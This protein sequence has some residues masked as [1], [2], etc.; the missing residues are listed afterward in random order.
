MN[1]HTKENVRSSVYSF[2]TS[3]SA[4]IETSQRDIAEQCSHRA[5][6]DS[7]PATS[8]EVAGLT[9]TLDESPES[10][11][12][13]S[14]FD[15]VD[16]RHRCSMEGS[17]SNGSQSVSEARSCFNKEQLNL[18]AN[19]TTFSVCRTC[20][21]RSTPSGC[22]LASRGGGFFGASAARRGRCISSGNVAQNYPTVQMSSRTGG[23][24]RFSC[25]CAD[26]T[27]RRAALSPL[28]PALAFR[29]GLSKGGPS[30]LSQRVVSL[31][32]LGGKASQVSG[33]LVFALTI[34]SA[35]QMGR[36]GHTESFSGEPGVTD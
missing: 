10:R 21:H 35:S 2:H 23:G 15:T 26:R 25:I 7:R 22:R 32:L 8:P 11:S 14:S 31:L 18:A 20:S 27:P 24:R 6:N 5:G 3:I 13:K 29:G 19:S 4:V 33:S 12:Q 28:S 16:R 9:S 34:R 17:N 1:E 36:R 30:L